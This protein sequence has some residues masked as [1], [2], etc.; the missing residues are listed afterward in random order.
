MPLTSTSTDDEVLA[1]YVDNAS[2]YESASLTKAKAF[3]T[4]CRVLLV[5]LPRMTSGQGTTVQLNPDLIQAEMRQA[6]NWA[7]SRVDTSASA[8]PRVTRTS[9]ENFR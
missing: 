2:Y 6:E 3:V 7:N 9:F 8:A 5:R 4:A 1:A